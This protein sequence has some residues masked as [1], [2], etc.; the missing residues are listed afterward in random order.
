[1]TFSKL[2]AHNTEIHLLVEEVK[3][4]FGLELWSNKSPQSVSS[5]HIEWL[6]HTNEGRE[7]LASPQGLNHLLF[8]Y[9]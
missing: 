4:D 9:L 6:K 5:K 1:M 8:R 2:I 7:F 3:V